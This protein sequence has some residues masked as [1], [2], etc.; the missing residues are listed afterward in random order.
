GFARVMVLVNVDTRAHPLTIAGTRGQ[1][2]ALH[3]VHRAATAA[4]R[5]AATQARFSRA[6]GRFNVPA[7]TAVVYVLR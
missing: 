3:P 7:R 5:R 2:W 4:D 1:H 6:Q